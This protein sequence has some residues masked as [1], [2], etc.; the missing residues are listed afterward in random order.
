MKRIVLGAVALAVALLVGVGVGVATSDPTASAEYKELREERDTLQERVVAARDE[1]R[2]AANEVADREWE[3]DKRS[4][5]LDTREKG[6]A[7]REAAVTA[8]EQRIAATSIRNGMWTVGV[9]VEPGTY[10]TAEPVSSQ[11]YWGIYRSGSNGSD[12]VENDIVIGG[13]P[14]VTL[15][16]GQDFLNRGCPDFVKQ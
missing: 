16:E 4:G 7:D 3:L 6:I 11:C 14:T 12:I 10:R 2:V 8:V 1:A 9:D 5:E 13:F 15:S